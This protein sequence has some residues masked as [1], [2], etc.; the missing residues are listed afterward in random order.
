MPQLVGEAGR[1]L[2]H[3]DARGGSRSG[4][5][6]TIATAR[7][8][9]AHRCTPTRPRRWKRHRAALRRQLTERRAVVLCHDHVAGPASINGGS[10]KLWPPSA[11]VAGQGGPL[12]RRTGPAGVPANA[13]RNWEND[14]GFHD[15]AACLRLAE[16]LGG[17]GGAAGRG[18]GGPGPARPGLASG[19]PRRGGYRLPPGTGRPASIRGRAP[20]D[21]ADVVAAKV[22][23]YRVTVPCC[24]PG[25][26]YSE[27][28]LWLLSSESQGGGGVLDPR[29]PQSLASS[30]LLPPVGYYS[31][32]ATISAAR[33]S[34]WL[35]CA[36]PRVGTVD[37]CRQ[38]TTMSSKENA[39][40]P[41]PRTRRGGSARR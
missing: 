20:A 27:P 3:P 6:S 5:S 13:L 35:P 18:G 26:G 17:A 19:R 38:P 15:L 8:A 34:A 31:P 9:G 28:L 2:R 7:R 41:A 1:R 14:R 37:F 11:D 4:A 25:A 39:H 36:A 30:S 29:P 16:A 32:P 12:P 10:R 22:A 24:R 23:W 40:E 33:P 21:D